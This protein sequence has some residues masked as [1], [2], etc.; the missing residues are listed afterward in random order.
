MGLGPSLSSL[1]EKG[2][3]SHLKFLE[4]VVSE[5]ATLKCQLTIAAR[6]TQ[7]RSPVAALGEP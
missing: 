2:N 5:E 7:A 4:A 6:I 3:W 1:A